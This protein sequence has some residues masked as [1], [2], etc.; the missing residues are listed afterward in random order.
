MFSAYLKILEEIYP[1]YLVILVLLPII[2]GY[3]IAYD[4]SESLAIFIS[5]L[6]IPIITIPFSLSKKI[7]IYQVAIAIYFIIGFLEISHWVLLKGPI[8]ITSLL[9]IS[10]TNYQEASEFLDLKATNKLLVLIPYTLFSIYAFVN[11]PKIHKSKNKLYL[12]SLIL[13]ILGSFSTACYVK[14]DKVF[15]RKGVPQVAKVVYSFANEISIYRKALKEFKIHKVD[16]KLSLTNNLQTFVLILG[17]SCNRNH[18]SLYGNS[19]K[20]NPKLENRNDL[21]I[22]D[23]VVSPYSTTIKNVLSILSQSNL[24]NNLD[25]NNSRDIIDI[26]HSAGFKTY[27]ISNQSPIGIWDNFVTAFAKKSDYSKFV[28]TSSNSSLEA[29]SKRSYDSKLFEPFNMALKENVAK[30]LIVLHLMGN[31]SYYSKRYPAEFNIFKGNKPK[32]KIIAEYK[33]SIL[34]NDFIVDSLFTILDYENTQN[35]GLVTSA[36]YLS[37]HGE[38]VYDEF[39]EVGHDYSKTLPKSNVEIPFLVWLSP[40]YIESNTTKVTTINTNKSKPFVNDDLF[41]SI[42]DLNN[43]QSPYLQKERS[44]FNEN[45]NDKRIRILVDNSDYDKN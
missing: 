29:L 9:T 43:I 7:I 14:G 11:P 18:M 3:I 33:N 41:H 8:T 30:K 37:D 12:I 20:T 4:L 16:A 17:E 6:W 44:I 5:L 36:I 15:I 22:Y 26:F 21:I 45:F 19:I 32:E 39:N 38:N 24:E 34:Y 42:L 40:T 10:N 1:R 35:K 23:N 25:I 31:H 28:N 13:L 2:T 27:W